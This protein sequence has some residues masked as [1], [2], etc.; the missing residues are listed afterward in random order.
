MKRTFVILAVIF[1]V[2]DCSWAKKVDAEK[3][4]LSGNHARSFLKRTH[5]WTI[6]DEAFTVTSYFS[7]YRNG[8][9][10]I[11]ECCNKQCDAEEVKEGY[12]F[13]SIPN[14][15]QKREDYVAKCCLPF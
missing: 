8:N 3:F 11:G 4:L 5:L 13:N 9:N 2:F 6:C 1:L 14:P 15:E 12:G 10:I 7:P